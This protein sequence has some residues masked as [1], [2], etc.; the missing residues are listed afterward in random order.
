MQI[1]KISLITILVLMSLIA[2]VA[3]IM[4]MPQELGF[5]EHI[6]MTERAVM[7]LGVIQATGGVLLAIPMARATG[8]ILAV[9]ALAV[10]GLALFVSGNTSVGLITL[11]PIAIGIWI[12]TEGTGTQ[13]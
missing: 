6:G 5:L 8:A 10:S 2:G 11:F 1:L 7:I 9:A 13:A 3:K 12:I 4:Q